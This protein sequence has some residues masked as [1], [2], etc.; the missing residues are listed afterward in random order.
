MIKV[1]QIAF[2]VRTRLVDDIVAGFL[3][4][5]PTGSIV[6]LGAGLDSRY[7]RLNNQLAKWFDIDLPTVEPLWLEVFDATDSHK[8]LPFSVLDSGWMEEIKSVGEIPI[9]FIAEGLLIHLSETQ[10]M[11]LLHEIYANF[12]SCELVAELVSPFV[13][14]YVPVN[15]E[16]TKRK[17]KLGWGIADTK[18]L[19]TNI[20]GLSILTEYNILD[21]FASRWGAYSLLKFIPILRKGQRVTHFQIH[22][23]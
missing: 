19:L 4:K 22:L 23:V 12:P 7:Y 11:S 21:L 15:L 20:T 3:A 13:V 6:N 14:K 16:V 10:V 2:A 18:E 17:K 5:N 8:F 1:L 9:L